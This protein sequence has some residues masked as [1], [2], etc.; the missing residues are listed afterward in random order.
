VTELVQAGMLSIKEGYRLMRLGG[1]GLEQIDRLKNASEERIFKMLD[2]IV[3]KGKFTMPDGYLDLELAK[4]LV[5]QYYNLYVAANIEEEKAD[6]LR[7]WDQQVD[8]LAALGAPQAP[9]PMPQASPQ[10]PPT[11]PLIP[12]SPNPQPMAS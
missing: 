7:A 1:D 3:E 11:S 9:I 2:D 6:L 4:Q 12:N 10:A 5:V 8:A